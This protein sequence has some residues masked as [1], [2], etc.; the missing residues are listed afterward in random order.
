MLPLETEIIGLQL[1][2]MT[3]KDRIVFDN[4]NFVLNNKITDT[5][6]VQHNTSK[7]IKQIGEYITSSN[8][9]ARDINIC[10]YIIGKSPLDLINKKQQ[11]LNMTNPLEEVQIIVDN[12]Y[13]VKGKCQAPVKWATT[14][15]NNNEQFVKFSIDILVPSTLWTDLEPTTVS[16]SPYENGFKFPF[17]MSEDDPLVYGHRTDDTETSIYNTC[18]VDVPLTI[19]ITAL[20]DMT[21]VEIIKLTTEETFTIKT[22]I[23][24]GD[25]IT[26]NTAFGSKSITKNG[27]NI[28]GCVDLVNSTW[29][30]LS[31]GLNT[32]TFKCG[33][34]V[35]KNGVNITFS[36]YNSYWGVI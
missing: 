32:F 20:T 26:I 7:T 1:V 31:S 22:N 34:K 17:H 15:E 18:N 30:M 13:Q 11:L 14:H 28:L 29:L 9:N 27:A 35:E 8:V 5:V 6:A 33:N 12:K 19:T 21:E 36:Y 4:E 3:T 16:L 24:P 25:I 2:N 23:Q 10:G